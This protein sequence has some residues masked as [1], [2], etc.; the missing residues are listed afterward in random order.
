MD[1]SLLNQMLDNVRVAAFFET[2]DKKSTMYA[3]GQK[4]LWS[5]MPDKTDS[6][7]FGASSFDDQ[8][9]AGIMKGFWFEPEFLVILQDNQL[10]SS[11]TDIDN[12]LEQSNPSKELEAPRI[13]DESSEPDWQVRVQTL[14]NEL[15]INR[16]LKKVVFGRQRQ[17]TLSSA[18]VLSK[19]IPALQKQQ[20]VYHV[21]IKRDTE[22]FITATP[23]RLVKINNKQV[24]T[25]AVAG[26]IRRGQI[27]LEDVK[28]GKELLN[29]EKNNQEH[30]YVVDS[31]V[32]QLGSLTTQLHVPSKPLLLKN[33]QVQHLYTPIQGTL[34][35][36]V[37]IKDVV[38]KLHPTPALGGLPKKSALAYIRHYELHPRGLFASPIGYFTKNSFGEFVVGIRSMYVNGQK[39]VLF[40]GAGIVAESDSQQ[41]FRETTLKFQPMLELLEE[42]SNDGYTNF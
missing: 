6:I 26:T 18:L 8:L 14:I 20:D 38:Q 33:K 11:T 9:E 40:A 39:S 22:L 13:I 4:K 25:A 41:E 29:S 37:S 12:Y 7:I 17:V 35:T 42:L 16:S 30:R 36:D 19:V 15:R 1:R 21:A 32:Q 34:A 28:L 3:F 23:E 31:I 5:K 10:L 2:S 24:E 27:D